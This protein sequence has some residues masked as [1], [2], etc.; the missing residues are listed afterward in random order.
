MP[1]CGLCKSAHF[2]RVE[3]LEAHIT[4]D[5][6]NCTPYECEKCRFAKFPTEYAVREHYEKD[7]KMSDYH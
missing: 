4:G 3:E 5:H 7:H 6:F 2:A 1:S